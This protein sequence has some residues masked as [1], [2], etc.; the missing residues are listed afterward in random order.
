M[1]IRDDKGFSMVELIVYVSIIGVILAIAVPKY[2]NALAMANTARI[3]A[4]LQTMDGAIM[5]YY[6]ENGT[7]PT[8]IGDLG[9]YVRNVENI[10]PPK[11]KCFLRDGSTLEITAENYT[12]D[13]TENEALCQGHRLAEFGHQKKGNDGD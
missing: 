5:M 7:Y 8:T 12:M 4:D 1:T 2:T 10:H 9:D 11:G 3:Q 13:G 6:S